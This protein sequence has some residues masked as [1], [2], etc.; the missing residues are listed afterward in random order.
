MPRKGRKELMFSELFGWLWSE[1]GSV[2]VGDDNSDDSNANAD[3][4]NADAD[5]NVDADAEGDSENKDD[6][7]K[8]ADRTSKFKEYKTKAERTDKLIELGIL[9]ENS[10]G[11]LVLNPN[12]TKKEVE[13]VEDEDLHF[14]ES[15]VHKDSWPLAQKINK[16]FDAGTKNSAIQAF[17]LLATQ[18]RLKI[19][20]DYPEFL[21]KDSPLKKKA[22]SILKDD[23][24]FKKTYRGNPE[25]VYWAVKRASEALEN[26]PTS[27]PQPK[28][29]S[30]IIGKGDI[31]TGGKKV[32][33]ISKLSEADLD[34]LEK[35]ENERLNKQK[36]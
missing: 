4:G 16:M 35:E 3:E 15:E 26:K 14:K 36:K 28:K 22:L 20:E 30:F 29:N 21:Q 18:A 5:A 13:K 9:Q 23:P 32:V 11:E 8:K 34:K 10:D 2:A 17:H 12:V 1:R 19:V 31:E 27:K 7:S 24:E 25:A 6:T 33:D